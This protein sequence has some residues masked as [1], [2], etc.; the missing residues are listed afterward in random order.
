MWILKKIFL[1]II[2]L[3]ILTLI[4]YY[5]LLSTS[6]FENARYFR[7]YE[8]VWD[9]TTVE[10]TLKNKVLNVWCIFT[11]VTKNTP[12]Q[13]KFQNLVSSLIKQTS[14]PLSLHIISDEVSLKIATEILDQAVNRSTISLTYSF[15]DVSQSAE[16]MSDIVE[17]M[18]PYFSSQPGKKT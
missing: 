13:Y 15:Y 12:F 11:K 18:T 5:I 6:V 1:R 16:N 9:K 17:T 8:N 4:L 3:I 2:I 7:F 10:T 14:N